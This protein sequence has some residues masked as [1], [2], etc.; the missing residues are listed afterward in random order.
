MNIAVA[1][2]WHLGCVISAGL[3]KAGHRVLGY[4]PNEQVVEALRRGQAP[5]ME[6]GLD[7]AI[8]EGLQAGNLGFTTQPAQAI[9]D[10]DVLW[11][12]FD[13]PVDDH[14]RADTASVERE[15]IH[16]LREARSG[17]MVLVSSQLPVGTI[18]RMEQQVRDLYPERQFRFACSP[19]NLRLGQ[20]LEYFLKPD[21]VVVGIRSEIDRAFLERMF[22]PIAPPMEWMSVESA[23]MA[24]HAINAFLAL[25]VTFANELAVLC[26]KT[27]ADAREVERALKS[28]SR[29][30][31]KAYVRPGSAF[32]GGTLARDVVF[33]TELARQESSPISLIPAIQVSND[34]HKQWLYRTVTEVVEGCPGATIAVL[35]LTYKPGTDTL[36]RST[37][38]EFCRWASKAGFT[39]KAHDPAVK[40]LP[41]DLAAEI[42][43][44][45][46]AADACRNAA[47]IVI[48]TP[49][50]EYKEL[51]G[52]D[53]A[54]WA[55]G[56]IIVDANRF[57]IDAWPRT[58]GLG[59]RAVGL[60][61]E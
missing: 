60:A 22:Q 4:D 1:G 18:K 26:E 46:T 12:A 30:G 33:L 34:T 29:I 27:G 57:L 37:S 15:I 50:P 41:D 52:P 2:L 39:V 38:V 6:P 61:P 16:L 42:E 51:R 54:A 17:L 14:D 55:P 49:W 40:Q 20:A 53:I 25:S 8:Q 59:F 35:G 10:A 56:A 7:D 47:V 19:E 45:S 11:V 36:R 5:I 32:A 43:L 44:A 28:E 24:K 48:G 21:R 58:L 31:P 13:T 9:P 3:A 23:E